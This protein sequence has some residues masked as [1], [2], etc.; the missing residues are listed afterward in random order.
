[1]SGVLD[2]SSLSPQYRRGTR[3]V[4]ATTPDCS[5]CHELETLMPPSVQDHT[6]PLTETSEEQSLMGNVGATDEGP[7]ESKVSV[8]YG[9]W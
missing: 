7:S 1:M 9:L 2:S 5:D 4:P 6:R 3:P 8:D